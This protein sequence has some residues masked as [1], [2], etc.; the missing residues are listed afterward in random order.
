M[1]VHHSG[2]TVEERKTVLCPY[3]DCDKSFT[4]KANL[5]THIRSA[6]EGFRF[7][8]GEASVSGTDFDAWSH[9]QGCGD[10][11]SSKA[12]LE[13][14]IRFKHLGFVRPK[15]SQPEQPTVDPLD[16][17]SGAATSKN[18]IVCTACNEPFLRQYDLELHVVR[19][20]GGHNPSTPTHAGL[21]LAALGISQEDS[22]W[23]V[24]DA[25]EENIFASAMDF[26]Q[27]RDEWADDEANILLLARDEGLDANIDPAL[28]HM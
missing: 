8:C 5:K 14:H 15:L 20:H 4:K 17:I 27:P 25:P 9:D 18:M 13:D 11:F 22:L 16:E 6:H 1:E 19:H 3:D 24:D 7:V 10:K 12:R 21:D 2:R 23:P 26:D 28:S